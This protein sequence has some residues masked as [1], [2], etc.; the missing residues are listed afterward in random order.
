[1]FS[2]SNYYIIVLF[3][4]DL[5]PNGANGFM[6]YHRP[7]NITIFSN[8]TEA[9]MFTV[10]FIAAING[11]AGKINYGQFPS[12]TINSNDLSITYNGAQLEEDATVRDGLI[13][14]TLQQQTTPLAGTAD[15][16]ITILGES[17]CNHPIA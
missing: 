12:G 2:L 6:I 9:D 13:T 7:N 17:H 14:I 11:P 1:M 10:Y 3:H 5:F 16:Y 15:V 8:A 4:L